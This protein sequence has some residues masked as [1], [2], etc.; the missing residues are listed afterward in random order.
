M[1]REAVDE[2]GAVT[3]EDRKVAAQLSG[4]PEAAVYGV[5]TFY[6]DLTQPRGRRHVRV[7][8][9]TACWAARFDEQVGELE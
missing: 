3:D 5:S 8:T 6:D 4:L 1:L 9:G 2:R 7:C